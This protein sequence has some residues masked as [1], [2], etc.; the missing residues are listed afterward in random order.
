MIDFNILQQVYLLLTGLQVKVASPL[1]FSVH[2]YVCQGVCV[3]VSVIHDKSKRK[4]QLN[5]L[6]YNYLGPTKVRNKKGIY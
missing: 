1:P 3:C 4:F 6:S 5:F 2:L